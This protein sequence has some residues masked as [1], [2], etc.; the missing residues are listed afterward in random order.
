M[1]IRKLFFA[2]P[3]VLAVLGSLASCDK[4]I[5]DNYDDCPRG[6]YVNFYS[7][8]EC[9]ESPS[10]PEE[11]GRLNVYAFDRN[12]ILRSA[13]L[14]ENVRLSETNEWLVPLKENGLY[15]ILAWGNISDHYNLGDIKVGE[16]TKQ[17]ILMRLKQEGKW[18]TNIDGT[19]LWYATSPVVELKDMEEAG[20]QYVRT[21]ANF[22]EYTNRVTVTIDSLP[23]PEDYVIHLASSNGSYRFDGRVAKSDSTYYPGETKVVGDSTCRAFFTTLKLE[24]G[25]ENTLSVIHKP[26]GREMFR[27]D[28]V[29][30]ILSSQ[31]AQNIN[32]RCLNDF[33]VRLVAHHCNCPDATY[34]IVEV[35][36]NDWL[37]HS[38]DIEL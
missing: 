23:E 30:V 37:V 36:V 14:F 1:D 4:M 3:V 22:R 27:T 10:Y 21:R 5:Y 38:Y 29:G 2:L 7:Q 11:I 26:T 25:H 8:T 24:S 34:V 33:D 17:E 20:D 32:L 6:V 12:D 16:T 18:A 35:W 13:N 31:Y 28:L 19:T 9:A 15:T